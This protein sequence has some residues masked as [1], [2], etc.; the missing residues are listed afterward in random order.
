MIAA[1]HAVNIHRGLIAGHGDGGVKLQRVGALVELPR[2]GIELAKL[3]QHDLPAILLPHLHRVAPERRPEAMIGILV[4]R[5]ADL[6]SVLRL[7]A[8]FGNEGRA[9]PPLPRKPVP[10]PK[11]AGEMA[12]EIGEEVEPRCL[13]MRRLGEQRMARHHRIGRWNIAAA[14][15]AHGPLSSGAGSANG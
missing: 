10:R 5:V 6:E 3:A 14:V 7:P 15:L 4:H 12:V 9:R 8:M 2:L 13:I 1:G 11:R